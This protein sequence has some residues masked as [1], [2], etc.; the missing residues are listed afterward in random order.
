M[1][2]SARRGDPR[3][4]T[5]TTGLCDDPGGVYDG[6]PKGEFKGGDLKAMM[7]PRAYQATQRLRSEVPADA[8]PAP[9]DPTGSPTP[10]PSACSAS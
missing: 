5:A 3:D 6:D 10:A 8:A 4:G 1:V 7:T 9:A 2:A